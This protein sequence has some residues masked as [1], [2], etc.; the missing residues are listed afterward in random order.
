LFYQRFLGSNP[1][2]VAALKGNFMTPKQVKKQLLANGY[3]P[4]ELPPAFTTESFANYAL[5]HEATLLAKSYD[6]ECERYSNKEHKHARRVLKIP[7]PI[8]Y[9]Q[10][11]DYVSNNWADVTKKLEG[12]RFFNITDYFQA[13]D[14]FIKIKFH[15]FEEKRLITPATYKYILKTDI[16]KFYPTIYTH[17][18][19]WATEGKK[20]AKENHQKKKLH[21]FGDKLD[22]FIRNCQGKQTLGI[23]IGPDVSRLVAEMIMVAMDKE[24]ETKL[25]EVGCD[26]DG[27]RLIDDYFLCF[28]NYGDA[29]QALSIIA[30]T[31]LDYELTLNERK[32]EIIPV[33]EWVEYL[34]KQELLNIRI[35]EKNQKFSIRNYVNKAFSLAKNYPGSNVI[36]YAVKCSQQWKINQDAWPLYEAFLLRSVMAC[37]SVF[38]EVASIFAAYK[39]MQYPISTQ[40][41]ERMCYKMVYE[42]L[43][44]GNHSEVAWSFWLLK[45]FEINID[46]NVCLELGKIENSICACILLDIQESGKT[47]IVLETK[48]LEA[49]ISDKKSLKG[50]M[51]LLAYENA[52]R[53]W[54]PAPNY[55]DSDIFNKM[56]KADVTFYDKAIE[57]E[58]AEIGGNEELASFYSG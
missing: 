45:M 1:V 34:W 18:I 30:S 21:S 15:E 20:Q 8:S 35:S 24:I 26:F 37:P 43:P 57:I 41:I 58:K 5:K 12:S 14:R 39:D 27:Y 23:P 51:W 53:G 50:N 22:T 28:D 4:T 31:A 54:I 38:E 49:A 6:S 11:C 3:F 17:S 44:L 56:A 9:F 25:Y 36:K 19:P 29:E 10:L 48:G 33:A 7:N 16:S 2:R 13:K 40:H 46:Q 52:I 47:E 55:D 32:T 42:N